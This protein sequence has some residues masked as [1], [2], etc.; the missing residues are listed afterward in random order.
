[1]T[2]TVS[3]VAHKEAY[4]LWSRLEAEFDRYHA[5]ISYIPTGQ[6]RIQDDLRRYLCLRSAGF[7]EQLV[8]QCVTVYL[9]SKTGGPTLNFAKSFFS[10][11]PNLNAESLSKL[12]ARFGDD[13]KVRFETFLSPTLRE[14]LN[15]LA[16]LRNPIAHGEVTGGQKLDPERYRRLCKSIYDWLTSDLL[17]APVVIEVPDAD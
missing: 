4:A 2:V 17:T 6:E 7:L 12:L 9:E 1:M 8:F 15:D 11:A 3:T 16:S 5:A 10:Y 14:S 13:H